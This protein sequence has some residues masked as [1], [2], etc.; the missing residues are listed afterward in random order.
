MGKTTLLAP[1]LKF[2]NFKFQLYQQMYWYAE[3][4]SADTHCY[5]VIH[6]AVCWDFQ[7]FSQELVECSRN[8]HV[9][10]NSFVTANV[11]SQ[12]SLQTVNL[13]LIESIFKILKRAAQLEGIKVQQVFPE[14]AEVLVVLVLVWVLDEQLLGKGQ[15]RSLMIKKK[16]KKRMPNQNIN[17]QCHPCM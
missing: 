5:F 14:Q 12:D 13:V 9:F 17:V 4:H 16:R 3:H 2:H 11:F 15:R 1:E 6:F 8:L 10:F 7:H